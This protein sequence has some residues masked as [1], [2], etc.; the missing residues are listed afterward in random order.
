MAR[1]LALWQYYSGHGAS[2]LDGPMDD[3]AH[4]RGGG[5][6]PA[7]CIEQLME[8]RDSMG[9]EYVQLMNLG[10]GPSFGHPG[11]YQSQND[12]LELF[13]REVIPAFD[14]R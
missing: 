4:G 11:S 7:D 10:T 9:C 12:A 13:G 6:S 2:G 14:D 1:N 5:G 8:C 3:F